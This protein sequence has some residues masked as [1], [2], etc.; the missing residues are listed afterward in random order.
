MRRPMLSKPCENTCPSYRRSS[1]D[2]CPT[3]PIPQIPAPPHHPLTCSRRPINSR[4]DIQIEDWLSCR[5]RRA[6]IIINDISHLPLLAGRCH[7]MHKPIMPIERRFA[8]TLH[9]YVRPP[10][11]SIACSPKLRRIQP[12]RQSQHPRL[13]C[14]ISWPSHKP[15]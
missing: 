9:Q 12:P 14:H 7:S 10:R 4:P 11:P 6:R 1:P 5:L 13:R 15:H 8:S 3:S 2:L